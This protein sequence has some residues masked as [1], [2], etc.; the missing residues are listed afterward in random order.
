MKLH[1]T[2]FSSVTRTH[3]ATGEPITLLVCEGV[4]KDVACYVVDGHTDDPFAVLKDGR[5][6]SEREART[7]PVCWPAYAHYRR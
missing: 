6:L 2:R 3:M 5:K 4:V 1:D 7:Y